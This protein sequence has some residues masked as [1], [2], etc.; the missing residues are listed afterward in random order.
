MKFSLA[1]VAALST[2]VTAINL[3]A[4]GEPSKAANGEERFGARVQIGGLLNIPTKDELAVLDQVL[5]EAFNSAHD[6]VDMEMGSPNSHAAIALDEEGVTMIVTEFVSYSGGGYCD[7]G[8]DDFVCYLNPAC[9]GL[10]SEVDFL[11]AKGA[12]IHFNFEKRICKKLRASGIKNFAQAEGCAFEILENPGSFST[13]LSEETVYEAMNGHP[14]EI[15]LSMF[16]LNG[17]PSDE[18]VEFLESAIVEAHNSAFA[19]LGYTLS[20]FEAHSLYETTQDDSLILGV[21]TPVLDGEDSAQASQ[22]FVAHGKFESAICNK[23][24]K[25]G[26]PVFASVKD[27]SFSF[28]YNPVKEAQLHKEAAIAAG[29]L[30]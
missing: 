29:A 12:M 26:L 19:K 16:G 18:A 11:V 20:A 28:V 9:R 3:R 4:S 2:A 21:A 15:E 8:H 6:S 27:C 5:V 17:T 22:I 30:A 1:I 14:A 13:R 10:A 24:N 25:S 23:L 7:D